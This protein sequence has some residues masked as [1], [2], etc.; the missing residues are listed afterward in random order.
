MM[1]PMI[2]EY[3]EA[4]ELGEMQE[5]KNM[6]VVPL[7][8]SKEAGPKYLTLKEALEEGLLSVTEVSQGGSVPELKVTN[9]AESSVLLLDGEEL[10]GAKQN[11]VLNTTILLKK[12]SETVIPVSCTEHGRW[13][14]ASEAFR[15][16][17]VVMSP[18]LR[19]R[20]ARSVSAS[21]GRSRNYRSDQAEVWDQVA[22]LSARAGAASPTGA[23]R[24]A[25]SARQHDLDDYL[26]AFECIDHQR[27]S[28]VTIGSA[29]VAFDVL[30]RGFAYEQL[31]PKLVKSYAMDA[32]LEACTEADKSSL[33]KA[34]AFIKEACGCEEKRHRSVGLGLDCR[35]QG[36]KMVGS[37][38]TY[39][40]AVIHAA[41]FRASEGDRTGRISSSR[42]RRDFRL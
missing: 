27:G 2:V 18:A 20:K 3:L 37:A 39:R 15:D 36:A 13:S 30:S 38:L 6:G 17:G 25:F 33:D 5:F 32:L 23:M 10:A 42:G 34:T 9:N 8:V 4:I 24:D 26:K 16:S 14:Y 22:E 29:V 40:K 1:D 19:M 21:L 35:F 12:E 28:L 41:F 7:L 11:R 31:H